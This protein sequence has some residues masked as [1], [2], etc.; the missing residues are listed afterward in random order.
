M[1]ARRWRAAL[2][3][4][5]TIT[6]FAGA[7]PHSARADTRE[8]SSVNVAV[9][10]EDDENF[11][12]HYLSRA[13]VQWRDTWEHS[14]GGLRIEQGCLTAGIWYQQ[15]DFKAR[16]PLGA[17]PYLDL[18]WQQRTDDERAYE[19]L[20]LDFRFP[21]HAHG[22]FGVRFRPSYDKSQQDF[23]ALW[24]YGDGAS[25]LQVQASFT[26]RDMFNKLWAFR[27][28]VVGGHAEPYRAHPF[29]PGIH[30][31]SRGARHRVE[32]ESAWLTPSRKKVFDPLTDADGQFS[33]WGSRATLLGVQA[34]GDWEGELRGANEQVLSATEFAGTPGSGRVFRRRWTGEVAVRRHLTPALFAEARWLYQDR[35]QDWQP[36]AGPA[37]FRAYDRMPALELDW[38]MKPDMVWRV[39]ALYN[40]IAI[41]LDGR[42]QYFTYGA[43]KESRAWI[44]LQARFGR[45]QVQGIEGIELDAEP[46]PVTFHHDKGFL[47]LQTTF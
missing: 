26:V 9:E 18:A 34:F 20:Q 44:G 2:L 3:M 12:D 11:L 7:R 43:R 29:E 41:D 21:T 25:P 36:P 39:G 27:Q 5:L 30:V 19:Y 22:V 14:T 1:T 40:R 47:S 17:H 28:T 42:Q 16:A 35:S 6:L 23:A 32:F 4:A 31:V 46:Y 37:S 38:T 45:V 10:E 8:W 24:D 33:L 13:P 15:N